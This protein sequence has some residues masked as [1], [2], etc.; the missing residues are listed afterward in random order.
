[1]RRP[2]LTEGMLAVS[3]SLVFWLVAAA[4]TALALAFALP[5]LLIR[6]APPA[7]PRRN[8][9]NAAICRGE[10]ADLARQRDENRLTDVEYAKARDEI[11]R[12]L[13]ADADGD[14]D[15]RAPAVAP[16]G[17]AT[18]TAIALPAL[19]FGLYALSGDPAAVGSA[20]L[21]TSGAA[22]GAASLTVHRDELVRHLARNPGDGRGW[23]LLARSDFDADRFDDAAASYRKALAASPK[24]AADPEVWCEYADALGMA[25]G[26]TLAGPPRELVMR[27][28][29]LKPA[30]HKALEMA[31]S[32]AYEQRDFASAVRYWRQLLPQL[33]EGSPQ[34]RELAAAIARA[35]RQTQV[36][37]G[38]VEA[39]R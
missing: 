39:S 30:H 38:G 16:R 18:V 27:A 12:R 6:S 3:D 35:E 2:T 4:M 31:G 20:A 19:A 32:A 17:V 5:R 25:Q 15:D 37:A 10:L 26:G 23:V 34:Q 21:S 24:I 9:I 28:L 7:R 22:D 13:L 36:A 8:A 33:P 11:E 14:A 1:M 29:A